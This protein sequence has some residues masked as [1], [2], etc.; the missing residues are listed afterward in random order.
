MEDYK[1]LKELLAPRV[2][3]KASENLRK[4]IKAIQPQKECHWLYWGVTTSL[5]TAAMICGF[6][7]LPT[8]S[9][10]VTAQ[11]LI[12]DA[13]A[14][15]TDNF[16]IEMEARTIPT[17]NFEYFDPTLSPIPIHMTVNSP[18]WR[19]DKGERVACG[20]DKTTCMWVSSYIGWRTRHKKNM[21]ES[22]QYLLN[23]QILLKKESHTK[24]TQIKIKEESD[25]ILMTVT[26]NSPHTRHYTFDAGSHQLKDYRIS[27]TVNGKSVDILCT[28]NISY[29]SATVDMNT[30]DNIRWIEV[31]NAKGFFSNKS[32]ENIAIEILSALEGWD[33]TIISQAFAN[34]NIDQL[35]ERYGNAKLLKTGKAYKKIE[36]GDHIFVPYTLRLKDGSLQEHNLSLICNEDNS[37]MVDGGI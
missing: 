6:I 13:L 8:F 34:Y 18:Q 2:E 24:D 29:N 23:P 12:E 9:T 35:K 14:F 21:I 11:K 1:D 15:L 28:K 10:N 4:R 32:A 16:S 3:A 25:N 7:F 33:L 27:V 22:F 30:P 37:W 17:E 5:A 20:D 19:I 31:D 26:D 36:F